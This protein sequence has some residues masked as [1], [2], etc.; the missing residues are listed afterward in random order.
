M[1]AIRITGTL[2][3]DAELRFATDGSA[4]LILEIHQAGAG[5]A[6][7]ARR[8]VGG[9]EAGAVAARN[10]AAHLRKGTRVTVHA[11]GYDI[12]HLPTPHLVLSRVDMIEHQPIAPRHEPRDAT[13]TPQPQ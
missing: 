12:E 11:G 9:G 8:R 13:E 4:W 6:V 7:Q 5:L 1:S 10:S 3:R 2:G